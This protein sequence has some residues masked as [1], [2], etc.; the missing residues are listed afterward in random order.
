MRDE[1]EKRIGH[2]Y[3]KGATAYADAIATYVAFMIDRA[4]DYGSSLAT[5]LPDDNAI[6]GTF[7]RQALPMTWDFCEGNFFGESSAAMN[8]IIRVISEALTRCPCTS[9][10]NIKQIDAPLNNY[11]AEKC[12]MST[13]PP[14]YDNVGYAEATGRFVAQMGSQA[15]AA[16]ALAYRLFEIATKKGW[17]AEALVYNG[18]AQEWPKLEEL[19]SSVGAD[20]ERA[21]AQGTLEL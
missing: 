8:T 5:W 9:V 20:V 15:G 19:A 6:R 21:A 17:A 14:Y 10:G 1:A 18:L 16:R 3:P 11:A 13:D 4:A 12:V 2:L 7:G